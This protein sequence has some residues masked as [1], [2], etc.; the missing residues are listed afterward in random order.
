MPR[1]IQPVAMTIL[2]APL[3]LGAAA[4]TQPTTAPPVDRAPQSS[5]D[6]ARARADL[7]ERI[8][9]F[10]LQNPVED[11]DAA[12]SALARLSQQYTDIQLATIEASATY[13]EKHPK[14]IR[15][16]DMEAAAHSK[17]EVQLRRAMI[18][19]SAEKDHQ[20]LVEILEQLKAK[21]KELSQLPPAVTQ[22]ASQQSN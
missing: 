11:L 22:P 2:A 8:R 21:E 7:E 9:Q 13:G 12:H 17:Y 10:R 4:A 14:M 5:A 15:M 1:L 3:L 20:Q 16:R 18:M 19:N 6:V